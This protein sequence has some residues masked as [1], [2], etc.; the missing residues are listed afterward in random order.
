MNMNRT[1]IIIGGH[2]MYVLA[3]RQSG[4]IPGKDD[5]K[6]ALLQHGFII[7]SPPSLGF[8]TVG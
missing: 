4:E 7:F 2:S 8:I 1:V 3:F 5:L 6:K